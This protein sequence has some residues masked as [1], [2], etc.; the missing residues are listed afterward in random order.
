MVSNNILISK[1]KGPFID[2]G[3]FFKLTRRD[4]FL[5]NPSFE[6][7]LQGAWTKLGYFSRS[8]CEG[9]GGRPSQAKTFVLGYLS[10]ASKGWGYK[11]A[12]WLVDNRA[13]SSFVPHELIKSTIRDN[14]NCITHHRSARC[15]RVI[16]L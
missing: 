2:D 15:T 1:P 11:R 12:Q 14:V 6:Q 13:S 8:L 7:H 10:V 4:N 5:H 9:R 3:D 16:F